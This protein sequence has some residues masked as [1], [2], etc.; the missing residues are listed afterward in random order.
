MRTNLKMP[1]AVP[2]E[3]INIFGVVFSEDCISNILK[4]NDRGHVSDKLSACWFV[5]KAVICEE[6]IFPG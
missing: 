2:M 1:L 5:N 4:Y 3:M 6:A